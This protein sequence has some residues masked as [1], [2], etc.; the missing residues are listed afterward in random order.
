MGCSSSSHHPGLLHHI[1]GSPKTGGLVQ[2]EFPWKKRWKSQVSWKN[3]RDLSG[4]CIY[5][6]PGKHR[7]V[8]CFLGNWIAGFRGF[9]LMEINEFPTV[10][11]QVGISRATSRIKNGISWPWLW[12]QKWL[13]PP[14]KMDLPLDQAFWGQFFCVWKKT[15][16]CPNEFWL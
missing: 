1:M 8:P 11:F 7:K 3:F 13:N 5:I 4:G 6:F 16:G 10:V 2:D 9:K 12:F 14:K 15:L